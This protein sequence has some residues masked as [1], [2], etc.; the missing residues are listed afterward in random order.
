MGAECWA[1]LGLR[2][3]GRV[4][5]AVGADAGRALCYSCSVTCFRKH[6]GK[7][8]ASLPQPCVPPCAGQPSLPAGVSG[9]RSLRA[10]PARSCGR[11]SACECISGF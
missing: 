6:K 8:P 2:G 10:S 1:W 7:A 11:A 4:H 5:V 3:C 9:P